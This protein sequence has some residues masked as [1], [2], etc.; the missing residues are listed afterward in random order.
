MLEELKGAESVQ[1]VLAERANV[2]ERPGG[3]RRV[4]G[5]RESPLSRAVLRMRCFKLC[6]E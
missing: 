3:G 1:C 2:A 6:A 4:K 5:D